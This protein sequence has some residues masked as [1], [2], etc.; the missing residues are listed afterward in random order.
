MSLGKLIM[1]L[2]PKP[3]SFKI[4]IIISLSVKFYNSY[5]N[6][7][8]YKDK[9]RSYISF[10]TLF[11]LLHKSLSFLNAGCLSSEAGTEEIA[12]LYCS[13]KSCYSSQA[14][15]SAELKRNMQGQCMGLS[16]LNIYQRR[17]EIG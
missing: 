16:E 17:L 1:S 13:L 7:L 10:R 3:S 15:D 8:A 5:F 4:M 12:A 9:E 14:H 2:V 11:S 6:Y